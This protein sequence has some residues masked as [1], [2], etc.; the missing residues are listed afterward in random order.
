MGLRGNR[1][2]LLILSCALFCVALTASSAPAVSPVTSAQSELMDLDFFAQGAG[3]NLSPGI[4][5]KLDSIRILTQGTRADQKISS[6]LSERWGIQTQ[7]QKLVGIKTIRYQG[8]KVGVLGCVACHSGRA[9]GQFIVGIGNK[10]IDPGQI[11]IDGLAIEKTVKATHPISRVLHP[12][13]K[14]IEDRSLLLM[15]KLADSRM[16]AST[17]GL[18]PVSL[19]GSWFYEIAG[20]EIPNHGYKGAVKVPSWFGFEKKLEV[21][22]F[23]DAIGKGHPEGW[24]IGVE[25]T[26]GQKPEVVRDYFEKVKHTSAL[27]SQLL[28]PP[29]PFALHADRAARGK[30]IFEN[31]CAQCHGTYENDANGVPIYKVPHVVPLAA[32]KT[33]SDRLDYVTEDFMNR[34]RAS[35]LSDLVQL[36]PYAGKRM[37]VAPRLHAIWA[38]FPYLHNGSVPTLRD[39]LEPAAKRPRFFSLLH[40]GDRSRFDSTKVGLTA[41]PEPKTKR[42]KKSRALYDTTLLGQSNQGHEKSVD[43][44]NAEK[45]DLIE[46]LKTL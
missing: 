20:A 23:A 16:R 28:P 1:L 45:N 36:S 18:V 35:P 32:V 41:T 12:Q 24:I 22:Q 8:M 42:A 10:N 30:T 11:G 14:E 40:A 26:S 44:S 25:I 43:L 3:M 31:S 27:I 21:G 15:K 34:V 17:Q 5:N 33:D 37:Y 7:D 29:Y 4:L 9:A 38:R 39:L 13:R 6:S 2:T 19:V 46:Y